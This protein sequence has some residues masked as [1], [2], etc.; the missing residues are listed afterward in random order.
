MQQQIICD[1]GQHFSN[2]L[3]LITLIWKDI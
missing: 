2:G 3:S 1:R